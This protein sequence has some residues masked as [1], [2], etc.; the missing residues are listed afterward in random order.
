[1]VT[2]ELAQAARALGLTPSTSSQLVVSQYGVY[3][4]TAWSEALF[5]GGVSHSCQGAVTQLLLLSQ[6]HSPQDQ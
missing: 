2:P 3:H 1:M 5:P 4:S 6:T